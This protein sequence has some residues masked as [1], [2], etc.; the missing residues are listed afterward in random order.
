MAPTDPNL[1]FIGLGNALEH[2]V[3]KDV[4]KVQVVLAVP[5]KHAKVNT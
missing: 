4:G 3:L 5:G 1:V 2:V